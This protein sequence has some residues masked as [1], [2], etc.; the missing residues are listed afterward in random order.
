MIGWLF[1]DYWFSHKED[2]RRQ[3]PDVLFGLPV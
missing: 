2:V 1:I 3:M